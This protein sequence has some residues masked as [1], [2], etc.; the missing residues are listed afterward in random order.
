MK[1]INQTG[2]LRQKVKTAAIGIA[3]LAAILCFGMH[4]LKNEASVTLKSVSESESVTDKGKNEKNELNGSESEFVS[5]QTEDG[6]V[7]IQPETGGIDTAEGEDK[8]LENEPKGDESVN[9][10][11][12]YVHVCGA[13]ESPGVYELPE[14]SRLYEAV[15]K[16]GG[17]SHDAA[18]EYVNLAQIIEDGQQIWIPSTE[19]IKKYQEKG[20]DI[21]NIGTIRNIGINA[22]NTNTS[23]GMGLRD[24]SLTSGGMINLNMAS[25]EELMTL[26]GIGESRADAILAYR[27]ENGNF[28]RIEDIMK[29]PG[30][31]NAA[32][33]KIKDNITV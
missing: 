5:L 32:F 18:E 12:I 9:E 28:Q 24:S 31:K 25:K 7:S 4:M 16:A 3:F 17:M 30:I 29:V 2:K 21:S 6:E 15:D 14:K 26:S 27:K 20:M 8:S 10:K 1:N 23:S 13:V 11:K 19:E 22:G 33:Q